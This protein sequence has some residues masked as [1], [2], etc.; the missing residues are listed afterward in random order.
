[1]RERNTLLAALELFRDLDI[2]R[3]LT[4]LTM[5]LYVCENEGLN[6]SELAHICCLDVA[7]TARIVKVLAG[8]VPEEDVRK[9]AMLFDLGTSPMDKR[10]RTVFLSENGRALRD[11]L[12]Q[13]IAK[14]APIQV[15]QTAC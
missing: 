5:F 7:S 12:E 9:S 1:M 8:G 4:T 6:V 15:L 14:A 3:G 11:Q 10:I 13:L 2:P